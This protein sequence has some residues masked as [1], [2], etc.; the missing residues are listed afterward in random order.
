MVNYNINRFC[1]FFGVLLIAAFLLIS[2]L[3][4]HFGFFNFDFFLSDIS[5]SISI[6]AII[7]FV[8]ER[9]LWKYSVFHGWL[10]PFPYLGGK[11]NGFIDYS[12][13]D[14]YMRKNIQVTIRQTFLSVQITVQTNE[15]T[16]RSICCSF[17]I[18]EKRGRQHLIYSYLNESNTSVRERSPIHYGTAQ[19]GIVED[20]KKL[21]GMYWT[22]RKSVGDIE[23]SRVNE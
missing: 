13:N 18:D 4:D 19:L 10:V 12:W 15:S 16:S 8:F 23:L 14:S 2:L 20:G 3:R 6:I 21:Q 9:W 5:S 17:D 7:A 22:D 11:W 1:W